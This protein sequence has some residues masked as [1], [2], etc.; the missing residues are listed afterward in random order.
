MNIPAP[1]KWGCFFMKNDKIKTIA[2][3]G[4]YVALYVVLK[5]VGNMIPFL[6]MPNG[7]SIELE[8]IAVFI[9]SYHLGWVKGVG[10]GVISL[11]V[12]FLFSSPY[13]LT[14]MQFIL[15]Y[16]APHVVIGMTS[17]L[18]PFKNVSK[19]VAG[20][21][22]FVI[23]LCA[24]FGISKSWN[25]GA[26]TIVIALLVA[27]AALVFTYTFVLKKE[28]FGIAIGML[29]KYVCNVLSGVFYYFPEG[30]AA[31]S[32]AAW[33]FSLGYNLWYNLVT[34]IVC[35]FVVPMLISRLKQAK[36]NFKA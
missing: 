17:L 35:I 22:S 27:V 8:L 24:F 7:G 36:I 15:D 13:I 6:D 26:V 12:S 11:F 16:I 33:T 34:M 10:V 20:I 25:G 28:G 14:P 23:A 5:L 1:S 9:A 19:T 29:L 32:A 30:A 18:W 31:G 2:Y 3:M 21:L 4:L